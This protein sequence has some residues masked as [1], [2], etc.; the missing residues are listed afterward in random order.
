MRSIEN[1]LF[2]IGH[3]PESL[4]DQA[5]ER[6]AQNILRYYPQLKSATA[7]LGKG[8]NA[9]DAL[10]ALYH[11]KQADW[12]VNIRCDFPLESLAPLTQKKLE[13]LGVSYFEQQD[14]PE[15]MTL[16]IDGLVG[17]GAKGALLSPLS[18]L[19]EEMNMLRN[20]HGCTIVSLDIPSGVE[21]DTG[22]VSAGS[23][24]ADHTMCVA[25]PKAGLLNS[26]ATSHVGAISL[27]PL[28]AIDQH[29]NSNPEV[30]LITPLTLSRKRR[31][32][33]THKGLTGHV[34]IW[35]G[36]EGMLGAAALTASAALKSGA[37]LVTVFIPP[38]L[39]PVL[40]SMVP[41][42]VMVKPTIDPRILLEEKFDTLIM[43]P[44][45]GDP[46]PS[47]A[48]RL[49]HVV[50]NSKVPVILD[51]DMLN[52][53]ARDEKLSVVHKNC[54]LTP[55][56]GEMRRLFPQAAD[57]SREETIKVFTEQSAATVLLKGA[58][59]L[60]S[61]PNTPLF[62]NSSG[63]PAMATAGQ[64]DVLSG[65][66]GGLC[67]QGYSNLDASK[68]AAWLAGE[69]AQLA[70]ANGSET[71]ETLTASTVIAQLALALQAITRRVN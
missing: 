8:H 40:A 20:D 11:L 50:E 17:I 22:A 52:L 46:V 1:A 36:S 54:I 70:L 14:A 51:A 68:L 56:P 69:A 41:H 31:Q 5:G 67:A 64:G 34:G 44:G 32:F 61:A 13:Q 49:L 23:V 57:L 16:L 38:T 45:I 65:I 30:Q 2:E 26:S 6:I 48:E 15:A 39:Y 63:S 35:A 27:I 43:G 9:G 42:E 10:V 33:D 58:R 7:Y 37:G 60:I 53:I 24:L 21:A 18:G 62:V 59:T 4:M 29:P 12:S 66:I 25:L 71:D 19:A 3:T 55:H 28:D 47:L